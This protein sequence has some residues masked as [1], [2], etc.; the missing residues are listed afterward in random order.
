VAALLYVTRFP[1]LKTAGA[2]LNDELI[3]H[4]PR[5]VEAR[6]IEIAEGAVL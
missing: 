4:L 1:M 2:M 5:R 3:R 6:I